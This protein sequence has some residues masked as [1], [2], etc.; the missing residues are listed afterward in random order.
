MTSV[1]VDLSPDA[2]L[3]LS[4]M[5][6]VLVKRNGSRDKERSF[7]VRMLNATDR[8][9]S[10]TEQQYEMIHF[11]GHLKVNEKKAYMG[12]KYQT[13]FGLVLYIHIFCQ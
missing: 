3:S 13:I 8:S 12:G 4:Y 6:Y 10:N 5:L 9:S 11:K 2:D 1:D 7:Y